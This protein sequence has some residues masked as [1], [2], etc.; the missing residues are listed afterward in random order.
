MRNSR[1][2]IPLPALSRRSFLLSLSE[3]T[4][5]GLIEPQLVAGVLAGKRDLGRLAVQPPSAEGTWS[6]IKVEGSIPNDLNGTLYRVAP[7][8]KMNHG[9]QLRH[10]FDGDALL[11]KY[12][13][14]EGKATVSARFVETP[15]RIEESAAGSM[16]YNEFGTLAPAPARG[17]KNQPSVNV[18]RWDG[19]LLALSEG[20][21]PSAVNEETLA[22]EGY[23]GFHGTLP[24]DMSF[25]AHPKFDPETG[26][27]YAFGTHKD[28]DLALRVY[29]MELDGRLTQIAAIPQPDYFMVHDML[30]GSEHLVIVV[31]P[32]HYDLASL[33]AGQV[34]PA[35][36]SGIAVCGPGHTGR[37]AALWG[38]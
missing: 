16:L 21:H 7:G 37:R 36:R 27:G 2:N 38:N 24:K 18:I 23:W 14:R 3:L 31:P 12:R 22:F 9:V 10:F 30:L 34:T 35:L 29:R 25:T 4:A 20:G 19:R 13:L 1:L 33:F 28:R 6:S 17:F 11:V 5:A 15:E 26:V 8:Q 32:V